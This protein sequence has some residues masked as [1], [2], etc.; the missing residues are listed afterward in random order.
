[1]GYLMGVLQDGVVIVNRMMGIGVVVRFFRVPEDGWRV[2][3][4]C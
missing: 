4:R 3:G 1:M 2:F